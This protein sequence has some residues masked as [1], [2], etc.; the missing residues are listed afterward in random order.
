MMN[1]DII[2]AFCRM[3][4][5]ALQNLLDEKT[6]YQETTKSI[7]LKKLWIRFE[8]FKQ[9]D[10]KLHN[11]EGSCK[12]KNGPCVAVNFGK[13]GHVFIAENS[14]LY[15]PFIFVNNPDGSL[16]SLF[17]CDHFMVNDPE[18]EKILDKYGFKAKS[19]SIHT[20]EKRNFT[21]VNGRFYKECSSANVE[22]IRYRGKTFSKNFITRWVDK[23]AV[24]FLNLNVFDTNY[25][26]Q[27]LFYTMYHRLDEYCQLLFYDVEAKKAL[28]EFKKL[29][30]PN[31]REIVEW[32]T[33]NYEL[34]CY[35]WNYETNILKDADLFGLK[36][37]NIEF[38]ISIDTKP[39]KNCIEFAQTYEQYSHLKEKYNID[40]G[41]TFAEVLGEVLDRKHKL[42][43]Q[44]NN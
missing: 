42:I 24:L 3:D 25:R 6:D 11:Y 21:G 29:Y 9:R 36:K 44:I 17:Y 28:K 8:E 7:F 16:K 22:W 2:E 34:M 12:V 15:L 26:A 5:D 43:A 4:I 23:H 38:N 13:K 19:L 27:D 18:I 32:L 31:E 40:D 10:T 14:R 35:I 41:D 30:L 33:S 37:I 39:F 1:Q 20:D